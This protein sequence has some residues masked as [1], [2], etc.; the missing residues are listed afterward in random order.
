MNE[1]NIIRFKV[2]KHPGGEF[3]AIKQG[4]CWPAFFFTFLWAI[5]HRLWLAAVVIIALFLLVDLIVSLSNSIMPSTA[6]SSYKFYVT[7][8]AG[9]LGNKVMEKNLISG[10]FELLGTSTLS[11]K[12]E[13]IESYTLAAENR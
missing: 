11:S 1:D 10:G 7:L 13:A 3:R 8:A 9:L 12:N 6:L 2:F 5:Y 4:F